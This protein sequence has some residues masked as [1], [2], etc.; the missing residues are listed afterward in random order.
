V[1]G[2]PAGASGRP[3]GGRPWTSMRPSDFD[4][5]VRPAAPV[6]LSLWDD[7]SPEPAPAPVDGMNPL[8]DLEEHR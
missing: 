8:F 3:P 4:A 7:A 2:R 1:T 6:Q 5:R